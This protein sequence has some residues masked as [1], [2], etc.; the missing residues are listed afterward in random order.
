MKL[1]SKDEQ[2]R[3]II[4]KSSIIVVWDAVAL[5]RTRALMPTGAML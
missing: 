3:I 1:C 5:S 4:E 2:S